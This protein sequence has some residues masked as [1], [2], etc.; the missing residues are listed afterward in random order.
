MNKN[1]KKISILSMIL[2]TAINLYPVQSMD[3]NEITR[4]NVNSAPETSLKPLLFWTLEEN[5]IMDITLD[6]P[7]NYSQ[8][9]FFSLFQIDTN[10]EIEKLF[11]INVNNNSNPYR[12][13]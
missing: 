13:P 4:Q 7:I 1:I 9:F 5:T 10:P 6:K 8:L 2:T 3:H 11:R 12:Y